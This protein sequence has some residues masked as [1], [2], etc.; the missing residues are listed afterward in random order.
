MDHIGIA[1]VDALPMGRERPPMCGAPPRL[2]VHSGTRTLFVE[3]RHVDWV[4]AEGNYVRLHIGD[5][6][7]LIRNT[8]H[9]IEARLGAEFVRIHRSRIVNVGKVQEL[10]VATNGEYEVILRNGRA[11]R[12][13]R[14]YRDKVQE[15]LRRA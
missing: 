9:A 14:L 1:I 4:Q 15:R 10:R 8:M 12:V 2:V 11:V 6:S 7:H 5:E 3:P 13:S